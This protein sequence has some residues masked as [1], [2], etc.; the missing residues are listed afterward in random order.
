MISPLLTIFSTSAA[1]V[2]LAEIG[3]KTM[4]LAIVLATRLRRPWAVVA[5]IL[6]ATV[7]NH[8]ASAFVGASAAWLLDARWF[9]VAVALGF[10]A[11]AVWTLVPDRLD[12]DEDPKVADRHHNWLAAFATT[13]VAFFLV[14]IGDKTQIAT[15]A[16][17]AQF[18]NVATVAAGTTL[19]M[20]IAD[21]P[22]V[23]LGEALVRIVPLRAA[24]IVAAV[25][26]AGIGAWQ[27]V[28]LLR[29]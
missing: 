21:A 9:R 12:D 23:F 10:I 24:R 11:M 15:I 1:V 25:L 5:G 6:A 13:T 16:L 8:L 7:T 22:A 27:L 29:G 17:A 2:T 19:G 18:Q 28:E 4:L 14:E 3:D 20:M 26:F